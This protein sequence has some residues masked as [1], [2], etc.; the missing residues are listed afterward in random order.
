MRRSYACLPEN[1]ENMQMFLFR[2]FGIE[3]YFFFLLWIW[4]L[5]TCASDKK[6][7]FCSD[8]LF[9]LWF[10]VFDKWWW[11][12]LWLGDQS[13]RKPLCIHQFWCLSTI[14]AVSFQAWRLLEH[15]WW[16]ELN[17]FLTF[18]CFSLFQSVFLLLVLL[19]LASLSFKKVGLTFLCVWF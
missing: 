7:V 12:D 2:I 15:L 17:F 13:Q 4:L 1:V 8:M 14:R 18:K 9:S 5:Q 10:Q 16:W 3:K 6:S 19:V 11:S